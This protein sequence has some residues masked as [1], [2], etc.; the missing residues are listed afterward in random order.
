VGERVSERANLIVKR[1]HISPDVAMEVVGSVVVD[2]VVQSTH[3]E[4]IV[5]VIVRGNKNDNK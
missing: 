2:V 4:G 5:A 1:S 3:S